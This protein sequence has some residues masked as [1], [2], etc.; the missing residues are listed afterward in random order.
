MAKRNARRRSTARTIKA[1]SNGASAMGVLPPKRVDLAEE[2]R[3]VVADLQ[4]IGIIAALLILG[5]IVLS[6]F[7]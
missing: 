4:R 1:P 6:F 2:Y 7:L 3:Y 5:L